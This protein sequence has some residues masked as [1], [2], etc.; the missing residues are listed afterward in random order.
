MSRCVF[1]YIY[2]MCIYTYIFPPKSYV[3]TATSNSNPTPRTT[4]FFFN[5]PC[6]ICISTFS[7]ERTPIPNINICTHLLYATIMTNCFRITKPR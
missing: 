4:G 3:N 7:T 2:S 1:V 5:F 6:S